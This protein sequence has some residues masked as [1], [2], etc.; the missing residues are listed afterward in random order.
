VRAAGC[1]AATKPVHTKKGEFMRFLTLEDE[2]GMVEVTVFPGAYR[3][4]GHVLRDP[5]PYLVEGKVESD[6]GAVSIT[7]DRLERLGPL[8]GEE[9]GWPPARP[10]K[11]VDGSVDLE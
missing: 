7:A 1:L 4:W 9:G 11:D 6:H 5:G 3:R 2:T 10:A 8:P